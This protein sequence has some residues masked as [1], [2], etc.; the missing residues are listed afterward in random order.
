MN[1]DAL[2]GNLAIAFPSLQHWHPLFI[3]ST[4]AVGAVECCWPP[5]NWLQHIVP[6]GSL[7]IVWQLW[8]V[9]LTL[10]PADASSAAAAA[11]HADMR[12]HIGCH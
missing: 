11:I 3:S 1:R 9:Q 2:G 7:S 10:A 4:H 6:V 12:V 8:Q 5:R